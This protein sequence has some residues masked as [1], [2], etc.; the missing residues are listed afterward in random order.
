MS[1]SDEFTREDLVAYLDGELTEVECQAIETSLA[2]NKKMRTEIDA[3]SKTWQML[4]EIDPVRASEEF[5][6]K[7]LNSIAAVKT[8][9]PAKSQFNWRAFVGPILAAA[10]VIMAG[11]GGFL[12]T[13]QPL[14]KSSRANIL[15]SKQSA[16]DMELIRKLHVYQALLADSPGDDSPDQ[17]VEFVRLL[18]ERGLF[19]E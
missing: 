7:T 11:I 8:E 10:F 13:N 14:S 5:S 9:E 17:T 1:D 3:L 18:Q 15:A 2:D 6:R 16:Q 12:L 4:D 19:N